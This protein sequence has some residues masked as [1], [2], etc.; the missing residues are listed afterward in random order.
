MERRIR[1]ILALAFS[2]IFAFG[3]LRSELPPERANLVLAFAV[4]FGCLLVYRAWRGQSQASTN[5]E[6]L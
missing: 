5:D 4:L 1:V 3:L 6:E 2:S